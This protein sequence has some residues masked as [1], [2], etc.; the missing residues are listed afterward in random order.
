[1]HTGRL[2]RKHDASLQHRSAAFG[3][4]TLR[5]ALRIPQRLLRDSSLALLDLLE[6]QL[7]LLTTGLADHARLTAIRQRD[8]TLAR[9]VRNRQGGIEIH[10]LALLRC[11]ILHQLVSTLPPVLRVTLATAITARS[12]AVA[13][14]AGR[15]ARVDATRLLAAGHAAPGRTPATTVQGGARKCD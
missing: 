4:F 14:E 1:M 5:R 7:L 10:V 13:V 6:R 11:E 3:M 2:H 9:V 12:V 15:I 8:N